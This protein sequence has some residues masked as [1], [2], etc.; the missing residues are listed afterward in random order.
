MVPRVDDN[1]EPTTSGWTFGKVV[2]LLLGLLGMIGFGLCTLCGL[3]FS[4]SGD[5]WIPILMGAG[6]TALSTWLAV[7][8]VRKARKARAPANRIDP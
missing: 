3:A 1:F 2:G 8:M 7:A 5:Y 4:G 6:M